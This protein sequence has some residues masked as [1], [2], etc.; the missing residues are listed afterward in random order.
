M[1]I[2]SPQWVALP[3]CAARYPVSVPCR[4]PL[5]GCPVWIAMLPGSNWFAKDT[6]RARQDDYLF[7][8]ALEGSSL[9]TKS[10]P[11]SFPRN[12]FIAQTHRRSPSQSTLHLYEF[13]NLYANSDRVRRRLL[14]VETLCEPEN[15]IHAGAESAPANLNNESLKTSTAIACQC[16]L[17]RARTPASSRAIFEY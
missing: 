16:P 3:V 11:L 7:R 4:V 6:S 9:I 2:F 14:R 13:P 15:L 8:V 5:H 17:R 12:R 1:H 10:I